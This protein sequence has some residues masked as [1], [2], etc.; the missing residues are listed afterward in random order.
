MKTGVIVGRFQIPKLTEG[1]W[2]LIKAVR[3]Q[4]DRLVIV[5]GSSPLSFTNRDPLSF[6]QRFLSILKETRLYAKD[7]LV[8]EDNP[9]NEVWSQNLDTLLED[10]ENPILFG[11][12]DSFVPH[13]SGKYPTM[14]IP[15]ERTG[16]AGDTRKQIAK[17]TNFTT[18]F[19]KG[20]IYTVENKFPTAY[21]TVDIAVLKWDGKS[22]SILLGKKPNKSTYCF[23]GGFV[24]PSD[25]SLELAAARELKEEV[26]NIQT[27][28]YKYIGSH[29]VNDFRYAGTKDGII[30]SLFATYMMGGNP[31]A[32]DDIEEIKW[33]DLDNFDMNV[34]SEHHKSLMKML[35]DSLE[36]K[37]FE[38]EIFD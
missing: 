1:H 9:S 6:E 15:C 16:C 27:H 19:L 14:L 32:S 33:F 10:Y 31:V 5:I 2:D 20:I 17:T 28:E 21:P 29:K 13:Y 25:L 8:L 22:T 4:T 11:S 12:R 3:S 36:R 24:D 30:T 34:L 37:K 38:V 35:K 7:I 23:I 26:G 18:D